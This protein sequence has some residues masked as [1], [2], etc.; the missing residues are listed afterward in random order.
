MS[1]FTPTTVTRDRARDSSL[2]ETE[3][4]HFPPDVT[5]NLR[6]KY[7]PQRDVAELQTK[8]DDT[9]SANELGGDTLIDATDPTTW[10]IQI[11]F[12]G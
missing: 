4:V 3:A 12:L 7:R 9:D 10:H 8:R 11:K 6:T 1:K 5:L 2:P